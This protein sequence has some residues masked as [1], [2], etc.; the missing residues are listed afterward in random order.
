MF[1]TQLNVVGFFFFNIFSQRIT[2]Q[3]YC[4]CD[5][6]L[7]LLYIGKVIALLEYSAVLTIVRPP[8]EQHFSREY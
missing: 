1:V 3:P 8:T 7:Q 5:V 6:A 2:R 4:L